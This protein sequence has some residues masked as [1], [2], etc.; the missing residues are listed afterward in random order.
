[1][2]GVTL[3]DLPDGRRLDIDVTGPD[4]GLPL[5]F[6][7]GTPGSKVQPRNLQRAA[8]ARGL[9][10]VTYSRAGYGG[11]TRRPGRSIIDVVPD[12]AAVL[13]HLGASRCLV[14]GASGGGPHALATAVGLS[15][16]VAA[17]CSIAGVGPHGVSDLEFLAGMGESNLAEFGFAVEGETP[18][19]KFLEHEAE[20]MRDVDVPG[21]IT[22][23][24]TLLPDV[25]RAALTGELGE[26]MLAQMNEAL[27]TG[28]DG[29]VDDDLAFVRHWG[30]ELADVSVPA[31]VW[32]GDVD[33]MVPFAHGQ[34]LAE[35]VP[36]AT[37]HLEPG[38]GH[39]S[40]TVGALDRILDE[41]VAAV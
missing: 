25:D 14:A 19:R 24:D 32:Q 9:R 41:L 12:I 22:A 2:P 37:P 18:L 17:V 30:F 31:F 23:M 7:H 27:R 33:L 26:D 28:V 21:L 11:S 16:R 29:W 8:G 34:W 15:D 38:E 4:D 13:D 5:V 6:H 39:L 20:Q 36:N 1:M 10:L 40:I 3:L 35:Q